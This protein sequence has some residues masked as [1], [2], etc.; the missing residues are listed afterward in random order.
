VNDNSEATS[1]CVN[2][3]YSSRTLIYTESTL[4]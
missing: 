4:G 1:L 2:P 3:T